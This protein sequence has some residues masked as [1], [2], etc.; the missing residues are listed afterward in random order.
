MNLPENEIPFCFIVKEDN[1]V[2]SIHGGYII[3]E[4]NLW[5]GCQALTAPNAA[6]SKAYYFQHDYNLAF[7]NFMKAQGVNKMRLI[8][9]TGSTMAFR[10]SLRHSACESLYD[11]DNMTHR[12]FTKRYTHTTEDAVPL[13][14]EDQ[15]FT[16]TVEGTK[17]QDFDYTMVETLLDFK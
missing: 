9:E 2:I 16:E 3:Y 12:E 5:I 6:G 8:T 15:V 10:A 1:K 11:Y 14:S 17:L 4:D 13:P 7:V